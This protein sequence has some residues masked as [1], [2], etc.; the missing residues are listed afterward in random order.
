MEGFCPMGIPTN[1][2]WISLALMSVMVP[3][4]L[5]IS[6]RLTGV[7]KEPPTP[8]TITV[9]A[10]TWNMSRPVNVDI[11]TI[12]KWTRNSYTDNITSIGLSVHFISYVENELGWW[13]SDGDDDVIDLRI[14]ATANVSEGFIYSMIIKF[15][16]IDADAVLYIDQNKGFRE[17]INLQEGLISW[18]SKYK[19]GA[20]FEALAFNR[21]KDTLL[22]I[23]VHWV[24]QDQNNV[25][26]TI[27]LTLE[28]TLF[29]GTAYQKII[30]PILLG[31]L[32]E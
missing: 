14:T 1:R 8:E 32:I 5:L 12:D 17:L 15:P 25:D 10:V 11:I 13:P 31:V 21:P 2:K 19:N 9:E 27:T 29:N 4:S 22:S 16:E 3:I 7:L 20:Y 28:T 24:L 26:H 30:M 23:M 18:S 6:F